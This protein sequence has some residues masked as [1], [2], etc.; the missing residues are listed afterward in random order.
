MVKHNRGK[1]QARE[2]RA[3]GN[4]YKAVARSGVRR[5]RDSTYRLTLSSVPAGRAAV[6]SFHI[7]L[8]TPA[9]DHF[10]VET[11]VGANPETRQLAA[12]QQLVDRRWMNPKIFGQFFDCHHA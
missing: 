7:A 9:I 12:A 8:Q 3:S 10:R 6:R 1:D 2:M 5:M 4:V 11:P